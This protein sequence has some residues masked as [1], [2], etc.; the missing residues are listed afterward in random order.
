MKCV[1]CAE[2]IRENP[3]WLNETS[4]ICPKC[5]AV[6]SKYKQPDT[7]IINSENENNKTGSTIQ[8]VAKA[9]WIL[10]VISAVLIFAVVGIESLFS[11]ISYLFTVFVSGLLV[12]GLGEIIILLGQINDKLPNKKE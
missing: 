5:A 8:T 1:L 4:A 7:V 2:E 3:T 10:G 9:I 11:L 6:T 12:Y